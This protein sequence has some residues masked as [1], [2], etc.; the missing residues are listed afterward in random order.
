MLH[1]AWLLTL[2][3]FCPASCDPVLQKKKSS[4]P[5]SLSYR[6]AQPHHV[7]PSSRLQR[8]H[9]AR[10]HPQN[11]GP[12]IWHISQSGCLIAALVFLAW[13]GICS[14]VG[15]SPVS[16]LLWA[17]AKPSVPYDLAECL[18]RC[19]AREVA[20]FRWPAALQSLLCLQPFGASPSPSPLSC[21]S[22]EAPSTIQ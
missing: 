1:Q 11:A 4:S 6:S 13:T 5:T 14:F 9:L 2:P 8:C 21:S 10:S 18:A 7:C 20:G 22:L 16:L 12:A 19:W 17:K 3:P 15:T